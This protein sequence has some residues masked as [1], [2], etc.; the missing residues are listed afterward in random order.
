M[1]VTKHAVAEAA[2]RF[3]SRNEWSSKEPHTYGMFLDLAARSDARADVAWLNQV[4]E[5]LYDPEEV[6]DRIEELNSDRDALLAQV[7]VDGKMPEFILPKMEKKIDR[8][9]RQI[10]ELKVRRLRAAKSVL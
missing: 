3:K 4:T 6:A 7:K 10:R 1:N 2:K 5:H 8:I 9:T